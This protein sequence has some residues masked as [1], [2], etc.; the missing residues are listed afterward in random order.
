MKRKKIFKFTTFLAGA[1][2]VVASLTAGVVASGGLENI[3]AL[4]NKNIAIK[5]NGENQIFRDVDGERVYPISY[6][7]TTYLPVRAVAG[8][9]NLPVEWN[10]EDNAVELGLKDPDAQINIAD[11]NNIK[12]NSRSWVIRDKATCTITDGNKKDVYDLGIG[13]NFGYHTATKEN[14]MY[15]PTYGYNTLSFTAYSTKDTV[16]YIFDQNYNRIA[17]FALKANVPIYNEINIKG[18]KSVCFQADSNVAINGC[19]YFLEPLVY[20]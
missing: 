4:L 2:I 3:S 9:A 10:A 1:A 8:L 15:A 16:A 20:N 17:T 12:T 6:N 19:A 11:N 14:A 13:F 5:Y 18:C 7:G